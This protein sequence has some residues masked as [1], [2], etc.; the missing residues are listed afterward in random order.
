MVYFKQWRLSLES[1]S[2]SLVG[3]GELAMGNIGLASE[4][5]YLINEYKHTAPHQGKHKLR[6]TLAY[7]NAAQ[8]LTCFPGSTVLHVL[9]D[10]FSSHWHSGF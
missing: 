6:R 10:L 9:S 1:T 7:N 2:S 5:R 4:V 8:E 3:H